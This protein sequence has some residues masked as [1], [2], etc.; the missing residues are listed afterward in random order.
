[1]SL[2]CC[3][4]PRL[5]GFDRVRPEVYWPW[6]SGYQ[7][8]YNTAYPP[9]R[10]ELATADSLRAAMIWAMYAIAERAGTFR[11]GLT[12]CVDSASAG[13]LHFFAANFVKASQCDLRPGYDR[14][15][16]EDPAPRYQ[17]AEA[18]FI[19]V[20]RL[21][22]VHNGAVLAVGGYYSPRGPNWLACELVRY[23]RRWRARSCGDYFLSEPALH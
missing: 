23:D 15:S 17:G 13:E 5:V 16:S 14:Y 19:W 9:G 20:D 7:Y 3:A 2:A 21:G 11:P 1:V 8:R 12:Y 4:R 10:Y 22:E 6:V 18:V